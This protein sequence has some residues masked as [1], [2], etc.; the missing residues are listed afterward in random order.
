MV[1]PW[2]S[3]RD[4]LHLVA[5]GKGSPSLCN[6]ISF[7][8]FFCAMVMRRISE[9][10]FVVPWLSKRDQLHFVAGGKGSPSFCNAILLDFSQGCGNAM[11]RISE[12]KIMVQQLLWQ[13]RGC[14]KET[15]YVL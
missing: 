15:S 11:Q 13:S 5:G 9:K 12:K 6:A 14:L 2:L 7:R 10:N 4:Q 3:K 8:L 1:V